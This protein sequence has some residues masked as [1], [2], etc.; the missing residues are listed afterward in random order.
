ML[1]SAVDSSPLMLSCKA[2]GT[3]VLANKVN[4]QSAEAIR[5]Q[6]YGNALVA[7]NRVL[8]NPELCHQDD[9]LISV[10]LLSLYEVSE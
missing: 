9:V 3:A 10:W 7:T 6:A 5:D 1:L 8:S 2:L 4:L